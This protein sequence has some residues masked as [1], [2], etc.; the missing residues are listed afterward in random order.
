MDNLCRP[1]WNCFKTHHN[2]ETL[3]DLLRQAELQALAGVDVG[4]VRAELGAEPADGG[5]VG[6]QPQLAVTSNR[7][8]GW[9][10]GITKMDGV[11]AH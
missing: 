2:W 10:Q 4:G 7:T 9:G 3:L 1:W 6:E 11:Y 5:H 8:T